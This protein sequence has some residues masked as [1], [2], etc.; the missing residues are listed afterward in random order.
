MASALSFLCPAMQ[1]W[2]FSCTKLDLV[3]STLDPAV[4]LIVLVRGYR[5]MNLSPVSVCRRA[6]CGGVALS[7]IRLGVFF[8]LHLIDDTVHPG[9]EFLFRFSLWRAF[10]SG[11]VIPGPAN[12]KPHDIKLYRRPN[13][14]P[15][16]RSLGDIR[17][18][19]RAIALPFAINFASAFVNTTAA[20]NVYRCSEL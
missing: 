1:V 14:F 5:H 11:S 4:T 18:P 15:H 13:K 7:L 16:L 19:P 17:S 8:A 9:L 10:F 2:F 3:E 6:L 12:R 20:K